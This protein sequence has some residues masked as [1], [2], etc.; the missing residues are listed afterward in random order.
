MNQ[1]RM[2]ACFAPFPNRRIVWDCTE[3]QIAIP[4][5][6]GFCFL[7]VSFLLRR[8]LSRVPCANG[9][10]MSM[11]R[12]TT[13]M[14]FLA[15]CP[16][17]QDLAIERGVF[18]VLFAGQVRGM[19]TAIMH[20]NMLGVAWDVAD[21]ENA[22]YKLH[23]RMSKA[24]FWA[25]HAEIGGHLEREITNYRLPV[26]SAMRLTITLHW[27]AHKT[28]MAQLS[29][30]FGI[31]KSTAVSITHDTVNVLK[32]VLLPKV[33]KFPTGKKLRKLMKGFRGLCGLPRCAG[34]ID[35]T[36]MRIREP[37]VHGDAYW[38]YQRYPARTRLAAVVLWTTVAILHTSK[39]VG[40]APLAM[41]PPSMPA[42]F[43][44][45][46]PTEHG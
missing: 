14:L 22:Q 11:K 4:F 13:T 34:A 24:S 9:S 36:F 12:T 45:R 3:I 20:R 21:W 5:G 44:G 37:L 23:L 41:Q 25:L 17:F 38:C 6:F 10:M 28:A 46:S 15:F 16:V 40:L 43:Q 7:M 30:T 26:S 2:P 18:G 1:Q 42:T 32:T 19:R 33:I 31:G 39:L 8:L 29:L 35:G 27:L